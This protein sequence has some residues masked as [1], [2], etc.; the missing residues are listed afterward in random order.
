MQVHLMFWG[1][2]ECDRRSLLALRLVG[3]AVSGSGLLPRSYN[4][5]FRRFPLAACCIAGNEFRNTCIN[6]EEIVIGRNSI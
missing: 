4:V 3:F 5:S 1:G 6:A 2:S